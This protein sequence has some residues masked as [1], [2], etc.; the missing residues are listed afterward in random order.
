MATTWNTYLAFDLMTTSNEPYELGMSN[1]VHI[2]I[3]NIP[4]NYIWNI[5]YERKI[6]NGTKMT[7][8]E[9]MSGTFNA[10][11]IDTQVQLVVVVVVVVVV[12]SNT[13]T[14]TGIK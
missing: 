3:I 7:K 11:R 6:A 14:T 1:M 13:F 4:T 9:V 5:I 8:F 2:W 10:N 12:V